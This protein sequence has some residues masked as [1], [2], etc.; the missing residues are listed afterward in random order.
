MSCRCAA[1]LVFDAV[2]S[3]DAGLIKSDDNGNFASDV[4]VVIAPALAPVTLEE[5][6]VNCKTKVHDRSGNVM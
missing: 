2:Q 3:S 5:V 4:A 1:P 6:A